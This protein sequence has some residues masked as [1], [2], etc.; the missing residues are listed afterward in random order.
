MGRCSEGGTYG[1]T[2]WILDPEV[3]VVIV[4]EGVCHCQGTSDGV[5][6]LSNQSI[7]DDSVT[8]AEDAQRL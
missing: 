6:G 2:V 4:E 3:V 5:E 8:A 7:V 1:F